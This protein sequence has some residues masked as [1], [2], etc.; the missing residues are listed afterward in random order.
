MSGQS[1]VVRQKMWIYRAIHLIVAGLTLTLILTASRCGSSQPPTNQTTDDTAT[2]CLEYV[3]QDGQNGFDAFPLGI[4]HVQN[5][6]RPAKMKFEVWESPASPEAYGIPDNYLL[7]VNYVRNNTVRSAPSKPSYQ[8][9]LLA[10]AEFMAWPDTD[11]V[12]DWILGM[13]YTG[14]NMGSERAAFVCV[15]VFGWKFSYGNQD[16]AVS[17]TTVHELGH[18]MSDDI[19]D[20]CYAEPNAHAGSCAVMDLFESGGT[21]WRHCY[22]MDHPYTNQFCEWCVNKLKAVKSDS[23]KL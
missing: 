10:V 6:F 15:A 8:R 13:N 18:N 20:C 3:R 22:A 11:V 9:H 5:S 4:E 21:L 7:I 12:E 14:G 19:H 16:E 2:V 23:G 17:G 1:D